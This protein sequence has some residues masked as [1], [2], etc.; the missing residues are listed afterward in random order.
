MEQQNYTQYIFK[1][2]TMET[3]YSF[4]IGEIAVFLEFPEEAPSMQDI[5]ES[6]LL[7]KQNGL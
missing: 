4:R 1:K 6:F 2:I 3:P 7:R 5:L